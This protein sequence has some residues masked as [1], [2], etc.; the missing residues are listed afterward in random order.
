MPYART[1]DFLATCAALTDHA[2]EERLPATEEAPGRLH[3]AMRYSVL[4]GG[5]RIRPA[6]AMA[7]ACAVGG[8]PEQALVCACAVELIHAYSLIHDDLPAMDDDDLRRGRPTTHIRFDQATAILAGD[9]LQALAFEWLAGAHSLTADTRLAM[10]QKLAAASGT[11]GMVGGQAIDLGAVGRDLSLE[12]LEQMHRR[13]TGALIE[14]SVRLGVL[15]VPA[16]AGG[17]SHHDSLDHYARAIG[18]AFQVQDDLLDI[19]G[20]TSIIGKPQGSDAARS[21]PTYPALMGVDGARA[22]LATL[23]EQCRDSLS[24]F[25]PEADALRGMAEF[26]VSRRY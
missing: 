10:V 23:L 1:E 19:E 25:G 8:E 24:G 11:G 14:A 5:K 22:Y 9:A 16:A 2:L 20:D 3:E 17:P 15:S 13:K 21:K 7:A 12:Q 18:L 4:G 26:V 6:L